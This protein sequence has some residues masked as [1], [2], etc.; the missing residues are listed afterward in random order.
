M[1][2]LTDHADYLLPLLA[3][4]QATTLEILHISSIKEDPESYG[5]INLPSNTIHAFRNLR[6]LGMDYDYIT[7]DLLEGFMQPGRVK[8]EKLIIHVHGIEP[9][10]EKITNSTWR[11]LVKGNPKLEVTLNLLHS[12]DGV[13]G[14]LDLLQPALPLVHLRMFFCQQIN[15]AGIN[16]IAQH[17]CN[18][19]QSIHIID[20][21]ANF[22]PN[23]YESDSPEDPFVML[24]WKC[25]NLHSFTLIGKWCCYASWLFQKKR[26]GPG[27]GVEHFVHPTLKLK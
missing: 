21:M 7:N 10:H 6:V 11:H 5:L 26:C 19:L 25:P 14:M 1:G 9:D 18:T 16:F 12:I 15:V 13:V 4:N 23:S 27:Q 8:L 3:A 17:H 24:A 20:G 2:E 22:Q